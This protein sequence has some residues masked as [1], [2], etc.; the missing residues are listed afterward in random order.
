MHGSYK[1]LKDLPGGDVICCTGDYSARGDE[2]DLKQFMKWFSSLEQYN[3]RIFID[4]N[5]D[6]FAEEYSDKMQDYIPKNVTYLF[7]SEV[8][9]DGIKFY[10]T[11]WQ[12]I[13]LNWAFNRT[14]KELAKLYAKIPEDTDV[15]LT[16]TPPRGILDLA[17]A[18]RHRPAENCGS[19]SLLERVKVVNPIV[20]AFGHIHEG[21]GDVFVGN[22]TFINASV[23]NGHYEL[24]NNPIIHYVVK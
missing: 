3:A 2:Y 12:P 15:L 5:H 9:I 17:P 16:H 8:V 19:I 14:E 10:G 1:G 6:L 7:D 24:V 18:W 23:L 21:Y 4:G 22:T 20:H 13:F 11:P